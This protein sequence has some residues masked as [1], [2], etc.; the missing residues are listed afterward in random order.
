VRSIYVGGD[1]SA[2]PDTPSSPFLSLSLWPSERG[3]SASVAHFKVF[4][5][6]CEHLFD[7]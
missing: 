5:L 4:T 2:V 3:A 7:S 6:I 1:S